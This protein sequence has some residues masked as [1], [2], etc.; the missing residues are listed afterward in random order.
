MERWPIEIAHVYAWTGQID[1]VF[2]LLQKD[3]EINGP[4]GVIVDP[5]FTSLHGDPRWSAML[6]SAG[7]S[8]VQLDRIEFHVDL[9]D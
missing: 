3:I 8:K 9:A 6:E 2:P 7:I 5:F 1:E 4:G